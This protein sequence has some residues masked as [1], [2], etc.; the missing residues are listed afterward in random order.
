MSGMNDKKQL[1]E[2]DMAWREAVEWIVGHEIPAF[3]KIQ[4]QIAVLK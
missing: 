1:L 3:K 4:C 2:T